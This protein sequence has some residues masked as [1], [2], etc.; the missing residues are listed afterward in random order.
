MNQANDVGVHAQD[1]VTDDVTVVARVRPFLAGEGND[2]GLRSEGETVQVDSSDIGNPGRQFSFDT[3]VEETEDSEVVFQQTGKPAAKEIAR[4]VSAVVFAFGQTGSGKTYT[5]LGGKGQDGALK[6]GVASMSYDAMRKALDQRAEEESGSERGAVEYT[7]ECSILQVY[8][9]RVYD[10]LGDDCE[11]ELR[12]RSHVKVRT[13]KDAGGETCDLFP[14]ETILPCRDAREFTKV[15]EK[16]IGKRAVRGTKMNATS[17]RSH[18]IV[19]LLV[20]REVRL[21]R[22]GSSEGGV[23]EYFA[24]LVFVDLAGNE[25]DSARDGV[26]D[27]ALLQAEGIDVNKSLTTLSSLLR[28]RS[29]GKVQVGGVSR[30]SALTRLLREPLTCSKIF[31]VACV[32]PL[33]SAAI[34][35][36]QTLAYAALVKKIK[37]N[38]ENSAVLFERGH[39]FPIEFIP[40]TSLIDCGKIARSSEEKTV[41]LKE[42]RAVV[43]KVFVSHR[44]LSPSDTPST[45]HPDMIEQG[46]PKHLLVCRAV[47]KMIDQGWIRSSDMV[48]IVDWIDF[49]CINQDSHNPAQQLNGSMGRIIGSCDVMITPVHDPDWEDWCT[50][51]DGCQIEDVFKDYR[52]TPFRDYLSRYIY[53]THDSRMI[54]HDCRNLKREGNRHESLYVD[55]LCADAVVH[56]ERSPY[57]VE[58]SLTSVSDDSRAG[59]Q[60]SF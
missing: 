50:D 2:R 45:A 23:R 1:S 34:T 36:A 29:E 12:M 54:Q 22:A 27:G 40:H 3:V 51:D 14:R 26:E 28:M 19:T 6:K 31:F 44:W 5:L 59:T 41:Y 42:L 58:T 15:L 16:G 24:R 8:L 37:T 7:I 4:G 38:A 52:A 46:H 11:T 39:R 20:R 49:A 17:S 32:S 57:I 10:L 18:C 43:V 33:K 35:S 56:R 9:G 48:D 21:E 47:E 53:P 25:R 13:L 55:Y 60:Q 30:I